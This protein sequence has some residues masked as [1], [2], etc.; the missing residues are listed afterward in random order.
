MK[1]YELEVVK[2]A[3]RED[4]PLLVLD[5]SLD[6]V[7]G[8]RG[9]NLKGDGLTREAIDKIKE[10]Q[11]F[12]QT[13]QKNRITYVLTKICI[14]RP[15]EQSMSTNSDKKR[16]KRDTHG[17]GR[18]VCPTKRTMESLTK[19]RACSMGL[20]LRALPMAYI[21]RCSHAWSAF[22]HPVRIRF[23]FRAFNYCGDGRG[24][25]GCIID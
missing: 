2:Y 19:A 7:D 11:Y 24:R 4:V 12:F 9:L 18:L 6:I 15:V 17:D 22:V 23:E 13:K 20:P 3:W 25:G 10:N 8:V 14:Y 5:L 16:R 21:P 1:Y